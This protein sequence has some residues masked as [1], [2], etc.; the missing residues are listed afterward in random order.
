MTL[1][2]IHNLIKNGESEV[3]ELKKSTGQLTRAAESLCAFLNGHGG[4]VIIGVTPEGKMVGQNITDKTLQDIANTIRNIEPTTHIAM[5]Q[6]ALENSSL[7]ILVLEAIPVPEARPYIF[8]GRPY[9]RTGTTTAVMPQDMYQQL[10][11]NRAHSQ[12]RWENA[13]AAGVDLMD[14]DREE[15]LKTVRTGIAAGRLP[16]STGIDPADI[17][18]RLGLR[19]NGTII[20]AA[21]V[22]FGK[23][24]LP[25]YTQCQIRLARFKGTNKT[26]FLDNKQL[27]GHAFSL[28]DE[29]MFFIQRHLPVAGKIT[30]GVIERIDEPIFPPLA[31]REALVNA[32]C[33]RDY[34]NPGGAVSVAIFDD[35]LEIWSE[36]ILPFGL[37]VEDLKR[38]HPSRPRNPL[39]A[40]V[41]FRRGLVERWGRGTQTIV[42]LCVK[43]GHPEPEFIEQAGSVGVRFLPRAYVAPHRIG[44]DLTTRQ[45]EI[46]QILAEDSLPLRK[47]MARMTKPPAETTV[48]DDLYHLKKLGMVVLEGYGRGAKWFLM[49]EENNEPE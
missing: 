30:P 20:N 39:I 32:F 26:E 29:A 5:T 17:L 14:L 19:S 15:I 33:H 46:L 1:D 41:F 4:K 22:L 40:D 6:V 23:V 3:L 35:R 10:L 24:F 11:L 12:N 45:R 34:A 36:G 44:H 28:L 43:A 25:N 42:E 8:D 7:E 18:D 21:V 16:E 47:I 37:K 38:D 13:A 27:Y 2:E 31:L 49:R 48:R 9:Y